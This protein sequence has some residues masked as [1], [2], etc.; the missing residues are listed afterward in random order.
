MAADN[1]GD[2][3]DIA[4]LTAQPAISS[5]TPYSVASQLSPTQQRVVNQLQ[6]SP[7]FQPIFTPTGEINSA[8]PVGA[9]LSKFINQNQVD[10][11]EVMKQQQALGGATSTATAGIQ[12]A[13]TASATITSLKEAAAR[14]VQAMDSADRAMFGITG[15][16]GA[17]TIA[18]LSNAYRTNETTRQ[19]LSGQIEKELA[20]RFDEDPLGWLMKQFTLPGDI[21]QLANSEHSVAQNLAVMKEI[22]DLMSSR[23]KDNE[24]AAADHSL[25]M[26][27]S[28]RALIFGQAK[29]DLA[30]TLMT[31]AQNN[32]QL[33]N[34]RNA[35]TKAEFNAVLQANEQNMQSTNN[36]IKFADEAAADHRQDIADQSLQLERIRTNIAIDQNNRAATQADLDNQLKQLQLGDT[37]QK[38]AAKQSMQ[39]KLNQAGIVFGLAPPSVD[40]YNQ[41]TDA[42]MKAFWS[43]AM[44]DPNVQAG[45]Y[46]YDLY[47]SLKR[48]DSVPVAPPPGIAILQQKLNEQQAK[49]IGNAGVLWNT[50]PEEVKHQKIEEGLRK[51]LNEEM[52]TV[53]D[54]GGIFSPG[55]LSSI[56][57]IPAVAATT[58]SKDLKGI[59]L[60]S[61]H[62]LSTQEAASTA[63]LAVDQGKLSISQAAAELALIYR[64]AMLDTNQKYGFK[65]MGFDG[66]NSSTGYNMN[67]KVGNVGFE[68]TV[69][70]NTMDPAQWYDTLVKMKVRAGI[71][72]DPNAAATLG[73]TGMQ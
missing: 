50:F 56:M 54:S 23:H 11:A 47:S 42:R 40:L 45:R 46:G 10:T 25:T 15:D 60:M 5:A 44:A 51:Y 72:G 71:S 58:I 57:N 7:N 49:I 73:M 32:I 59:S 19:L 6:M 38:I 22:D 13:A 52:R 16:G 18:G 9:S 12:E 33:L 37:T 28:E 36:A 65:R 61:N 34:I 55:T 64:S 4:A 30:K 70:I 14:R 26:E 35:N 24:L 68:S 20:I 27:Q 48:I 63:L 67:V 8:S 41:M 62:Q 53:P 1:E 17:A 39:D 29:Q 43:D 69:K 66:L 3:L 21:A 31:A 2:T